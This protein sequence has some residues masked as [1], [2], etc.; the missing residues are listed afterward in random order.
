M[1]WAVYDRYVQL[2]D[3]NGDGLDDII[4]LRQLGT[5]Y[6]MISQA[7]FTSGAP[8][9][10]L[11]SVRDVYRCLAKDIDVDGDLDIV[12]LR[13]T[14]SNSTSIGWQPTFVNILL[15]NDG[16]GNFVDE[17]AAR[18]TTGPWQTRDLLFGDFDGDGREDLFEVNWGQH[19]LYL[20]TGGGYF[21]DATAQIPTNSWGTQ[22][23]AAGDFDMDGDV[24]VVLAGGNPF[25]L[26]SD[27]YYENDGIGTFTAVSQRLPARGCD[28]DF[29]AGDVDR[30]GD[31]D[32][33][34]TA[35]STSFGPIGT[36]DSAI[37][38]NDGSGFF[39]VAP[40]GIPTPVDSESLRWPEFR[41]VDDDGWIDILVYGG[42]RKLLL[43]Q[44][45]GMFIDAT[46]RYDSV[47][48]YFH[49]PRAGDIDGDGDLDIVFGTSEAALCYPVRLKIAFNTS[50]QLHAPAAPR[51]GQTYTLSLYGVAGG[52]GL[53]ALSIGSGTI[54]LGD[55][56]VF[57]LDPW[58]YVPLP[59]L[60]FFDPLGQGTTSVT[61]PNIASLAGLSIYQQGLLTAAPNG[62]LRLTNLVGSSIGP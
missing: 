35:T 19:H 58:L 11:P 39:T 28:L 22:G 48:N 60:A 37:L 13:G 10:L 26:G 43:N 49:Y 40:G 29:A 25:G 14:N 32:L 61:I 7:G 9:P 17:T 31:L 4:V 41:D 50:R 44:G 1:P 24:D 8:V 56:G 57:R 55:V 30:D 33:V 59:N 23:G 36:R 3:F 54:P 52:V 16:S 27:E 2:G 15:I 45:G 47:C 21:I 12:I 46:A 6:L 62:A 20:G 53:A 51:V 38:A 5:L 18:W 42:M 34:A